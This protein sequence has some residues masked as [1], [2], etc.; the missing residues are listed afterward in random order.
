MVIPAVT[1]STLYKPLDPIEIEYTGG[2]SG[3]LPL[4]AGFQG[5][6]ECFDSS[7]VLFLEDRKSSC[8]RVAECRDDQSSASYTSGY[9]V[10]AQP[11]AIDAV[12]IPLEAGTNSSNPAVDTVGGVDF[13]DN[14]V[15]AISLILSYN[16]TSG[17]LTS[18]NV[19]FEYDR[20]QVGSLVE[21]QTAVSFDNGKVD[22]VR[23]SGSPG[24]RPYFPVLTT[25]GVAVVSF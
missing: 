10:L 13:C 18:T 2:G 25:P 14:Y 22:Q 3:T 4:P 16:E 1:S 24:Y 6:T 11:F 20:V 23:R 5:A 21:I 19:T 17:L 15:V 9:T 8:T 12:R 7:P